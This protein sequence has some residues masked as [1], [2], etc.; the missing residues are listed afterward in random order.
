MK[1]EQS[2]KRISEALGVML[3]SVLMMLFLSSLI[4]SGMNAHGAGTLML[5]I[6]LKVVTFGAPVLAVAACARRG[7]YRLPEM[8]KTFSGYQTLL[9]VISS[10]GSIVCIQLLY[11]SVF[12]MT[13]NDLGITKDTSAVTL[14]LLF[15]AH[16]AVPAVLEEILFRGVLLRALTIFRGLLAILISS[17][18]FALM[19]V[20]LYAFPMVFVCGFILGAAYL[21]TGS[22]VAT[23]IIHLSCNTFWFFSA[24]LNAS[25]SVIATPV[26]QG[27]FGICILMLSAGLPLLKQTFRT[28]FDEDDVREF[29]PSSK[30]WSFPMAVFMAMALAANILL[31]A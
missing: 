22:V 4:T 25:E 31:G 27:F 10:I 29:V 16:A 17:L 3:I 24:V 19:H 12:P 20:S 26:I 13:I 9:I 30:F 8:S 14:V 23:I 21:S 15:F 11:G 2:P 5:R 28:I 18:A 7:T 1:R 6:I